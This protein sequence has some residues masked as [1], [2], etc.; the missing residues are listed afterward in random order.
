MPLPALP[1]RRCP[2]C[3]RPDDLFRAR[4]SVAAADGT[5]EVETKYRCKGCAKTWADRVPAPPA[6]GTPDP[7][8]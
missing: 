2:A 4:R 8:A 5:P 3:D 7:A 1:A 6:P